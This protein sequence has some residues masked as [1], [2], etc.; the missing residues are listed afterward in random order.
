M[1]PAHAVPDYL[2]E[3][4]KVEDIP[5]NE[6][7]PGVLLQAEDFGGVIPLPFYGFSRP[8][9]DYFN[10]NLLLQNLIQCDISSGKNHV[11]LYDEREQG[12]GADALCS[13]RMRQHLRLHALRVR[14]GLRVK[15]KLH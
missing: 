12:K 15:Y 11:Y 4:I 14:D 3:E 5:N 13:L 8:S 1:L 2:D 6:K 10:S 7:I 9:A